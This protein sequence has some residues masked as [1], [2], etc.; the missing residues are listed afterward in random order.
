MEYLTSVDLHTQHQAVGGIDN[1]ELALYCS[2]GIRLDFSSEHVV[3]PS[4]S[5]KPDLVVGL[6]RLVHQLGAANIPFTCSVRARKGLMHLNAFMEAIQQLNPRYFFTGAH[7][8]RA[9]F[10]EFWA[11]NPFFFV[12]YVRCVYSASG[13]HPSVKTFVSKYNSI[14]GADQPIL[15]MDNHPS[16]FG[17]AYMSVMETQLQNHVIPSQI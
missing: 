2:N 4:L 15:L 1:D 9:A 6:V 11:Q 14:Y 3:F 7:C 5:M 16:L 12:Q 10:V 13:F 8:K 17:S